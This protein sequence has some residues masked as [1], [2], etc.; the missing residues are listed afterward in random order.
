[1]HRLLPPAIAIVAVAIIA[2]GTA[3]MAL[4]S[5]V[6]GKVLMGPM[7]P[8]PA[9]IGVECPA[10]PIATTVDVF[11][12][13]SDGSMPATP[14]AS[15]ASDSSGNFQLSLAPGRYWFVPRP[16]KSDGM[17]SSKPTEVTVAPT[18]LTTVTL[19]VDTGIR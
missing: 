2:L 17:A 3:G 15:V 19:T 4:A 11:T 10:K 8:G 18:G 7:C 1:M 14:V 16:P 6:H 13:R 9:Q 12:F 5:E